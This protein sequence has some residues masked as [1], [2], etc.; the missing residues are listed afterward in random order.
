MS[1]GTIVLGD[2]CV[3]TVNLFDEDGEVLVVD[4]VNDDVL[5]AFVRTDRSAL[6]GTPMEAD[7]NFTG[8]DWAQGV[9][10]VQV[11]SAMTAE[12]TVAKLDVEIKITHSDDT[13]NRYFSDVPLVT[14][15]GLIP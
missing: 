6:V 7:P 4:T 15:K 1:T 13:Q 11:D 12:L 5:V 8:A 9:I 10:K 3:L 2:D 14:R